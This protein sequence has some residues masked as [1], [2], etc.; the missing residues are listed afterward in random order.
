MRTMLHCNRPKGLTYREE[1]PVGEEDG[2]FGIPNMWA[3]G[4][5]THFPGD[6]AP[7]QVQEAHH[8]GKWARRYLPVILSISARSSA[9][10]FQV[11]ALAL[12]VTCSGLVA[13]AMTLETSGLDASQLMASSRI[14]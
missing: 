14:V 11:T 8:A 6:R 5:S 3:S 10:S 7:D 1:I 13:P 4:G 12:A 2:N 9:V